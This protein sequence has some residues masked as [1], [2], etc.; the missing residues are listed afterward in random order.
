MKILV[1]GASSYIGARV[2]FDLRSKYELVGTYFTHSLSS[3]FIQLD[4]TN[5]KEVIEVVSTHKPDIIIHLANYSSSR[6]VPKPGESLEKL[7]LESTRFVVDAA[8]KA[9]CKLVFISS[10]A[11]VTKLNP[12]G[13]CKYKSE[14]LVINSGLDYLVLRPSAVMGLSPNQSNKKIIDRVIG[15]INGESDQFDNSWILQPTYIGHFSQ[16]ITQLID[17]NLWNRTINLFTDHGVT[18]YQIATDILTY[19]NKTTKPDFTGRTIPLFPNNL[20]ELK[21][22]TLIPSTYSDIITMIVKEINNRNYY[23]I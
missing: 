10:M 17:K 7:N 19:F 15:V 23:V 9:G 2:Y 8:K 13:E 6:Y 4:I 18:Q 21:H 12:Y 20:E 16:I 22:F 5:Q 1:I 14:E 11:A 3:L